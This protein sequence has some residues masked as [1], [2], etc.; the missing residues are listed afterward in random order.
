MAQN[1]GN[2]RPKPPEGGFCQ[3]FDKDGDG[4]V[5]QEEFMSE[6]IRL[7]QNGD[8]FITADEAPKGP[9][10]VHGNNRQG[11]QADGRGRE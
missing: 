8:G 9:P 10:G 11:P 6:F 7:D 4:K 1:N 2:N 5:S 3:K